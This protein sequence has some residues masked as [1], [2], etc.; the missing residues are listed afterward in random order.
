MA[1]SSNIVTATDRTSILEYVSNLSESVAKII[2]NDIQDNSGNSYSYLLI[3]KSITHSDVITAGKGNERSGVSKNYLY[4]L[5]TKE[6]EEIQARDRDRR[7][8]FICTA[9]QSNISLP[10]EFYEFL[11]I[12]KIQRRVGQQTTQHEHPVINNYARVFLVNDCMKYFDIS[13]T[14]QVFQKLGKSTDWYYPEYKVNLDPGDFTPIQLTYAVHGIGAKEDIQ[15]HKL[16]R[17]IFR[18]D[19][20]VLLL[21]N[22]NGKK[23]LYIMLEKNPKFFTI[24]GEGNEAWENYLEQNNKKHLYELLK[25]ETPMT[26]TSDTKT[27]RFQNQWR[28]MLAREMMNYTPNDNE[29]FCPLTYISADFSKAGALFVASHIKEYSNCDMNEAFDINNGILMIANA[30]ALFDKHLI[31]INDDGTVVFSF[32]LQNEF[33]LRQE[34]KLTEKVFKAIL[35]P[36]RCK[37][38]AY[39]RQVFQTEEAKR[40]T[41]QYSFDD[42]SDEVL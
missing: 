2:K 34:I 6:M 7:S 9:H 24:I 13:Y 14:K 27:R 39:H 8:S 41:S 3:K 1:R 25:N 19:N 37:Y 4:Y 12:P 31:T 16:R 22:V 38:L 28:Q 10:D 18:S 29:V 33:K 20:L 15:F 21:R 26:E 11:G 23:H 35:N 30:D 32:L 17:S 40:K 5:T 42:L 36:E